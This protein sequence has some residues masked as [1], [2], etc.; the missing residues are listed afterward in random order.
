MDALTIQEWLQ[1]MADVGFDGR[2]VATN[3]NWTIHGLLVKEGDVVRVEVTDKIK[4][5]KPKG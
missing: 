3:I 5:N 2:F 1:S 4:Q